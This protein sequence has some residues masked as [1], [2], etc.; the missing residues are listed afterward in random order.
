MPNKIIMERLRQALTLETRNVAAAFV[1]PI[2]KSGL[3]KIFGKVMIEFKPDKISR[4]KEFPLSFLCS[5]LS[6]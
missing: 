3:K 4:N 2:V 1:F 6:L 5:N